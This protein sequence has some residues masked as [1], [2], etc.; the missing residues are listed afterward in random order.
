MVNNDKHH[1]EDDPFDNR[2]GAMV[3]V[4]K[5]LMNAFFEAVDTASK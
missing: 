3:T 2:A 5:S 4:F 1:N